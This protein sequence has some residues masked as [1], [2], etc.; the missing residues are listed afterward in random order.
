MTSSLEWIGLAIAFT[1]ASIALVIGLLAW[2]QNSTKM[3]IQWVFKVQE[4][5]MECINVLSE[6]DH[7]C[8]MDH[9]ESDY[10]IRKHKVLFRLSALIDRGRLLFN[11]V[12]KEEYGRSKHP[13]YRGFR[14]KIL[15]PLVAYYT[16]ME[17]L[18]VHQDSP[19]VVR[20]RLIKWRR[21][22]VSV[23]QDEAGPEWLD[24]MK[25]QTRN[26][27]GGAGI[28]IDAYTEAPEEAPQSS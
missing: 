7:L 2:R 8:L 16:S 20:A 13:A 23:L 5:G 21:Y 6:A 15:D 19:I 12:E 14:P 11:N 17:E 25:R 10:Q 1:Q 3:E 24:V 4:W 22:F 28:N 27:G 26:P 18:E 9:R